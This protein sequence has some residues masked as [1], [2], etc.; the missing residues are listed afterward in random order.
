MVVRLIVTEFEF[1]N[2]FYDNE[3]VMDDNL[4]DVNISNDIESE[5]PATDGAMSAL[6]NIGHGNQQ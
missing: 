4:L 3:G 1:M 5:H 6:Q 2:S